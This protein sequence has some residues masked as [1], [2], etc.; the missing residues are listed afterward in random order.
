[1]GRVG[2]VYSAQFSIR[3]GRVCEKNRV[4][5]DSPLE[6]LHAT[7]HFKTV[8]LRSLTSFRKLLYLIILFCLTY[9]LN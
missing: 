8:F 5:K 6:T 9:S 3:D 1:M 7:S 2:R 4:P